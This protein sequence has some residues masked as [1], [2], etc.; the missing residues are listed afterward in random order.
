MPTRDD[1]CD[2]APYPDEHTR[3]TL[4]D[5]V[6]A[7]GIL[8][9]YHSLPSPCGDPDEFN[10]WPAF[11]DDPVLRLHLLASLHQQLNAELHHA[12]LAAR[13]HGYT[14]GQIAVLLNLDHDP[15]L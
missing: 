4:D 9:G 12:A 7:L 6:E 13:D 5:A 2:F 3:D 11:R 1:V 15:D 8:R 14:H 10:P